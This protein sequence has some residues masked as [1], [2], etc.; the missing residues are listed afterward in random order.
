MENPIRSLDELDTIFPEEWH[1]IPKPLI[2]SILLLK[3]CIKAQFHVLSGL[4]TDY[5]EFEL[6]INKNFMSV[7]T[8]A[9]ESTEKVKSIDLAINESAKKIY[10]KFVAFRQDIENKTADKI[11][12][13]KIENEGKLTDIKDQ[14][15]TL[16]KKVESL[17]TMS[18]AKDLVSSMITK[19]EAKSFQDFKNSYVIPEMAAQEKKLMDLILEN[20]SRIELAENRFGHEVN[21]AMSK[22]ADLV[23]RYKELK[24]ISEVNFSNNDNEILNLHSKIQKLSDSAKKKEKELNEALE[25]INEIHAKVNASRKDSNQKMEYYD[26]SIKNIEETLKSFT[27]GNGFLL[28]NR[29]ETALNNQFNV[30]IEVLKHNLTALKEEYDSKI[31]ASK[32]S[33]YKDVTSYFEA[34]SYE[35][36]VAFDKYVK[37]AQELEEKYAWLP[38]NLNLLE[39]MSPLEARLF[40]V[41]ARMRTEENARIKAFDHLQYLI[42]SALPLSITSPILE[43]SSSHLSIAAEAPLFSNR[44]ED[45]KINHSPVASEW[46]KTAASH[47]RRLRSGSE[48]VSG[49][50]LKHNQISE[51]DKSLERLS[52]AKFS[53]R[54]Q[55]FPKYIKLDL[56]KFPRIQTP[57]S[58][59]NHMNTF[60]S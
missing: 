57:S 10:N 7:Q 59:S 3:N 27:E 41:E 11:Q 40:T 46:S 12:K 48:S 60:K 8:A 44:N 51:I 39:G 22:I 42:K 38:I 24:H 30:S 15:D 52:K 14:L 35:Q 56:A 16:T 26:R 29:S 55:L 53:K 21:L 23:H 2:D 19:S 5:A 25:N 4:A 9:L 28:A 36:K 37:V 32:I 43:E 58:Q 20:S 1:N 17:I 34:I 13:Q 33:I 50:R 54:T 47:E 18:Q 31:E 45:K 6:K 49:I